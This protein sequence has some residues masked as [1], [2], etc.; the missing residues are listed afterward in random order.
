MSDERS[1]SGHGNS[2]IGNS[3]HWNSGIGNSGHWNSG[4]WN[5]GDWNSGN[6]NSGIGNSGHFCTETPAPTFFDKPFAGTWDEA[7]AL[8]PYVELPIGCEWVDAADMTDA[9]KAAVPAHVTTGGFLRV[10]HRTVQ[11][12]FPLVWA[13]MDA[14]TK[15]RFL[16]LPNFDAKKFLKCTGVDVRKEMPTPADPADE[17]V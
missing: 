8:I 11:E 4:D 3:G 1:N 13:K 7:A 10:L 12:A 2:G 6:W 16:D 17:I 15:Q 5:S 9:E 14:E